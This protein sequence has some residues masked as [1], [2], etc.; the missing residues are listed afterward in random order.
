MNED[1]ECW[2]LSK[3]AGIWRSW[4]KRKVSSER[5]GSNGDAFLG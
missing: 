4:E 3:E 2:V 1:S 5:Q